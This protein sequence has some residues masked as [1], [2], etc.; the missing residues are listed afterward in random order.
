M[1]PGYCSECGNKLDVGAKFC[2]GCGTALSPGENETVPNAEPS[3]ESEATDN[4][5]TTDATPANATETSSTMFHLTSGLVAGYFVF[6]A[7]GIVVSSDALVGLAVLCVPIS[8]VTMYVDLRSL[9]ER[10]WST[11][12]IVWVVA[13]ILLYIVAA[14]LYVYKRRQVRS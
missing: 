14:P 3:P 5:P 2:R 9:D 12:P 11:R 6:F 1:S 7:L 10:L 8:W 4:P 13:A